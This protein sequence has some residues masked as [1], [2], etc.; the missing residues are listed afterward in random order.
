LKAR[1]EEREHEHVG[2]E[3]EPIFV[4][5]PG[6]KRGDNHCNKCAECG[7]ASGRDDQR[8]EFGQ[9]CH[10]GRG[11]RRSQQAVRPRNEHDRHHDEFGDEGELRKI[12]HDSGRFD[13]A[14]RDAQRF[15]E[16]DQQRRYER[17]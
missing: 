4:A 6:Q 12:N 13:R 10:R 5:G 14:H 11:R 9:R 2:C 3:D 16:P 17:A 1:S 7:A 8:A 15:R